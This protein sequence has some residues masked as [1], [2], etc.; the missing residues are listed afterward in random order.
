MKELDKKALTKDFALLK[1]L[2][3]QVEEVEA[4]KNEQL[5]RIQEYSGISKLQLLDL[6]YAWLNE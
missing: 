3:S 4:I 5:D 1:N 2:Y 6:Y